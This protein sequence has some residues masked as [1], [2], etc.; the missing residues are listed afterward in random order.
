[1]TAQMTMDLRALGLG[2]DV[3]SPELVLVDPDLGAAAR[4]RLPDVAA[5]IAASPLRP[6]PGP[7]LT[8]RRPRATPR[9][10]VAQL[11]LRAR[12]RRVSWTRGC[13]VV[14]VLVL[15]L[16]DMGAVGERS[17]DVGVPVVPPAVGSPAP[18]A[19]GVKT[20]NRP[21]RAIER[22]FVWAAT[23]DASGYHVEF[24][25]GAHRV[26][27]RD[28]RAPE[29]VLPAHWTYAGRAR[30]LQPG[31]YTWYVWPVI[32]G[33]RAASAAVQATVSIPG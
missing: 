26:F 21:A 31:R 23:S 3:T 11:I 25:R 2:E 5:G 9:D 16:V 7:A 15:L 29:I 32:A 1:M 14:T 28:T 18:P 12:E 17:V 20:N 13:A 22:R 30:S 27:A 6:A 8:F 24:F 33:R 10:L 19:G 4:A